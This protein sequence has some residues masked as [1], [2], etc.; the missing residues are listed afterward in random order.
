MIGGSMA[1]ED[2]TWDV[3]M[4]RSKFTG[5]FSQQYEPV[6]QPSVFMHDLRTGGDGVADAIIIRPERF[7]TG[8]NFLQVAFARG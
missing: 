1:P 6:L 4:G 7:S 8:E 2:S 3:L 5:T